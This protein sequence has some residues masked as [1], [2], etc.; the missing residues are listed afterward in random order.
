M[1]ENVPNVLSKRHKPVFDEY[2]HELCNVG[3]TSVYNVLDAR[4]F[5][6]PQSRKRMYCISILDG[7]FDFTGLEKICRDITISDVL[8]KDVDNKYYLT[9]GQ[10]NNIYNWK[11]RQRP[12]KRVL[13]VNSV[14]PT[15]T[16]RGGGWRIS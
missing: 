13:G 5:G 11:A 15:L 9:D 3:Y 12:L 1:W 10:I 2:I 6:I 16:A 14:C 7:K 8:E 4:D